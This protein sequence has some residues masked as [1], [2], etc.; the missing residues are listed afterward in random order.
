M[1][2]NKADI[3]YIYNS[4]K[5]PLFHREASILSEKR[6]LFAKQFTFKQLISSINIILKNYTCKTHKRN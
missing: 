6:I 3:V 4:F 5:N 2:K 1:I